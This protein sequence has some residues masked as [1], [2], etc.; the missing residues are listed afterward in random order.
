MIDENKYLSEMKPL[1]DSNDQELAHGEADD[2][3]CK[4]LEDL[5]YQ[6]VV[7]SYRRVPKWYS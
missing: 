4:M 1:E 2:L 3:L 7:D 6:S 5:G